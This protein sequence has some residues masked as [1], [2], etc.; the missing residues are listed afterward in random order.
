MQRKFKL[1]STLDKYS[2]S[3]SEIYQASMSHLCTFLVVHVIN[4]I[5]VFAVVP[6]FHSIAVLLAK[7]DTVIVILVK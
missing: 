4:F 5:C 1:E 6:L 7:A 3:P 2:Y